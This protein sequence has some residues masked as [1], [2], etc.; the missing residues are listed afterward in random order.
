MAGVIPSNLTG[1]FTSCS[2]YTL[3]HRYATG[4][5]PSLH[6][7]TTVLKATST[8]HSSI[9]TLLAISFLRRCQASWAETDFPSARGSSRKPSTSS[10]EIDHAGA[11][12]NRR[13][14]PDD[15]CNPPIQTRSSLGN[16]ITAI[17][18]GYLLQDTVN[19]LRAAQ[20]RRGLARSRPKP[21]LRS[22]LHYVDKPLLIHHIGIALALLRLQYYISQNRERGIYII[23]QFLLMNSST[24]V[25]NLRWWLR[26]YHP[27]WKLICLGSDI[28][29]IAVFYITR[30][31]LIGWIIKEYGKS[32]GYNS[33]WETYV[34]ALRLPCKVGTGALWA[35]NT[36]WWA[37]LVVSVIKRLPEQWSLASNAA[38]TKYNG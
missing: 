12:S 19:L 7:L 4:P 3:I 16:I 23:V 35:G 17:E 1:L 30:V 36:T 27:D 28:A 6:R 14:Y 34:G 11:T 13:I 21:N 33:A 15:S 38:K 8:L 20:L 32:H 5:N 10:D 26:T 29:F 24:P 25:L 22:F 31:W 9:T 37:L 18:C 2:A